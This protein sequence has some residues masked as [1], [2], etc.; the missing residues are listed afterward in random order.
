MAQRQIGNKIQ[1]GQTLNP[2]EDYAGVSSV[3][4]DGNLQTLIDKVG[5]L[6]SF[7]KTG[8]ADADLIRYI[9]N[10]VPVTRQDVIKGIE[11]RQAYASETYVDKRTIDFT[12]KLAPNTYELCNNGNCFSCMVR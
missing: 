4:D 1:F 8:K 6:S 7:W 10:I 5:K 9:P 12:I 3:N 11:P 2:L